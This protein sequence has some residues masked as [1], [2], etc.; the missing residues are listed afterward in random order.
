MQYKIAA[1]KKIA[2]LEVQ[3][4]DLL[5]Q[6]FELHGSPFISDRGFFCQALVEKTPPM[7]PLRKWS[8]PPRE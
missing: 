5:E 4:T 1:A 3:V 7:R 2:D 8:E 6:G